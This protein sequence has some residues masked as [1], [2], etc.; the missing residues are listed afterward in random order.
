MLFSAHFLPQEGS[1]GGLRPL[2][3]GKIPVVELG[4]GDLTVVVHIEGTHHAVNLRISESEI[5]LL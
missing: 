4:V 5:K 1:H 2:A 3:T